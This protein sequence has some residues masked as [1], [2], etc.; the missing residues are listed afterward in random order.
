VTIKEVRTSGDVLVIG[1]GVS[2]TAVPA[3]LLKLRDA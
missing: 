2:P 3:A 1:L